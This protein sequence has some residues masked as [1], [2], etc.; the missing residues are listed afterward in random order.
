[1]KDK[2]LEIFRE[3]GVFIESSDYELELEL[4][5]MQFVSIIVSLE[6]EF[7]MEIPSDYLSS[8]KLKTLKDFENV[9]MNCVAL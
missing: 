6:D 5:S 3:N 4:D 7:C 9:I 8:E 2:I 1:M